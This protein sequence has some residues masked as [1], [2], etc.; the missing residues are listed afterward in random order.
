MNRVFQE[1]L[2][3]LE[4]EFCG[5]GVLRMEEATNVPAISTF[6]TPNQSQQ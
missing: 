2:D 5:M 1:R 3:E 4:V 6:V